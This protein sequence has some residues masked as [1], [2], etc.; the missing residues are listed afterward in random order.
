MGFRYGNVVLG[1]NDRGIEKLSVR[2]S[3][4]MRDICGPEIGKV[5]ANTGIHPIAPPVCAEVVDESGELSA[6][7]WATLLDGNSVNLSYVV[8]SGCEGLGLGKASI[9]GA[10]SALFQSGRYPHFWTGPG[11]N[12]SSMEVRAQFDS[13][14]AAS[15]G[16]AY[17]LGLTDAPRLAFHVKLKRG[18]VF[19]EGASGKLSEVIKKAE[20]HIERFQRIQNESA[21][22][23]ERCAA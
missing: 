20:M 4:R 6:L 5:M 19:Y 11:F 12:L 3:E 14:N 22:L 9:S 8:A 17:A 21:I 2:G 7:G 16:V 10:L 23:R 15:R 1:W 13:S 18:V